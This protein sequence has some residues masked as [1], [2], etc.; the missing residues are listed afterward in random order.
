MDFASDMRRGCRCPSMVTRGRSVCGL[1][2]SNK[3]HKKERCSDGQNDPT[4]SPPS[5]MSDSGP[6]Q[7]NGPVVE[8]VD[9]TNLECSVLLSFGEQA[10]DLQAEDLFFMIAFED[11]AKTAAIFDLTKFYVFE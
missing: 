11:V 9:L 1:H 6:N 3:R 5:P 8:A 7:E 10:Q 2:Q 4:K